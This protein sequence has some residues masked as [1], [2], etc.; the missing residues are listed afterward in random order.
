MADFADGG[1]GEMMS[2]ESVRHCPKPKCRSRDIHM[3]SRELLECGDCGF[4]FRFD[5]AVLG[6]DPEI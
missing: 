6:V 2:E 1:E 5:E 4:V 3:V